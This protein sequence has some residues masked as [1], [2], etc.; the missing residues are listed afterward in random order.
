MNDARWSTGFQRHDI[1]AFV[2]R[3]LRA[4]L[5]HA[6]WRQLRAGLKI[7]LIEAVGIEI[8]G[9][10]QVDVQCTAHS[11]GGL[12]SEA[13]WVGDGQPCPQFGSLGPLFGGRSHENAI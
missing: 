10:L 5:R 4:G 1:K 9:L 3:E 11:S 13:K 2:A 8:L 7:L 12:R 6:P